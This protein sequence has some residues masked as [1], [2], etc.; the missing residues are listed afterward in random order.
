MSFPTCLNYASLCCAPPYSSAH[1]TQLYNSPLHCRST[2]PLSTF[3]STVPQPTALSLYPP[4]QHIPLNCTA[5]HCI[6]A[7][8]WLT[9]FHITFPSCVSLPVD[10]HL[11]FRGNS[12]RSFSAPLTL[13]GHESTARYMLHVTLVQIFIHPRHSKPALL[14]LS[15]GPQH[16]LRFPNK[17]L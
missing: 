7:A 4:T 13:R 16:F 1:S 15:V 6:V 3:H 8:A 12:F 9:L 5:A 14:Y 11:P 10:C 17:L 2:L